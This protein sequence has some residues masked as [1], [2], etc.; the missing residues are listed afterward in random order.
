MPYFRSQNISARKV[1]G[2]A[3]FQYQAI[4]SHAGMYKK[5]GLTFDYP[6]PMAAWM[7]PLIQEHTL[8][9]ELDIYRTRHGTKKTSAMPLN[10]VSAKVQSAQKNQDPPPPGTECKQFS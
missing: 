9:A 2:F 6:P 1:E 3:E 7:K 4:F 10:T 8:N 5:C